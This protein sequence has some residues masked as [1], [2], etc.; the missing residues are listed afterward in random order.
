MNRISLLGRVC[1][2][3][4]EIG[5]TSICFRLLV[6]LFLVVSGCAASAQETT[7]RVHAVIINGGMNKLMN[8]E[9]YWNDCAFLYR[10]LREDLNLPK[11]DITL[12]MS[13]GGEEGRDMLLDDGSGFASS[14]AD[15]DGDGE[16]D[17]W[18]PATLEQV[19]ASL[20]EMARKL[21]SDDRLFLFMIDH[22][23]FDS[24]MQQSYAWMW[25]GGRLYPT[26]LAQLLDAFHVE[27][28][29][30]CLGLCHAGGFIDDLHGEN[31]VIAASCM[32]NEN[33]WACT[34]R[35]YDEF[36]YHWI[37]AVAGH[38]PEDIPVCADTNG[39]GNISMNEAFD[40]ACLHDRREENPQYCS[41]PTALGEH[42]AFHQR[43]QNGI[44]ERII[45]SG[46]P[47]FRKCYDLQGRETVM[48]AFME[49]KVIKKLNAKRAFGLPP[50]IIIKP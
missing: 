27:S 34:D 6:A 20:S 37:C 7:G 49:G 15:L 43:P 41:M 38:D 40:Y 26:H 3:M 50:V 46:T 10:T 25:G 21:S 1:F 22:G 16:R 28:M 31:R 11:E 33:S 14:P 5:W 12:L 17:V 4:A 8:H 29:S 9:R 36:V 24:S 48:S 18:L 35:P 42:W 23:D 30:L 2:Y 44:D 13:D 45:E 47:T 32:E 19:D 39:D